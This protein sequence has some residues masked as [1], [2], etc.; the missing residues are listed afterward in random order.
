MSEELRAEVLALLAECFPHG[1]PPAVT[2]VL[3]PIAEPVALEPCQPG[4]VCALR[5]ACVGERPVLG[6]ATLARP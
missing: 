1:M 3:A 4:C 6:Q 5:S 2:E